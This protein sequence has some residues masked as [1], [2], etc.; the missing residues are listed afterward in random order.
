MGLIPHH[1]TF[2]DT[3]AEGESPSE[4]A[5]AG[6]HIPTAAGVRDSAATQAWTRGTEA[7]QRIEWAQ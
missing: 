2:E 4:G 6:A 3:K 5:Q 1:L 7:M